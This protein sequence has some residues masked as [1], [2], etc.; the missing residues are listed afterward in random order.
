MIY[1]SICIVVHVLFPFF[2]FICFHQL[3]YFRISIRSVIDIIFPCIF[4]KSEIRDYIHH[5]NDWLLRWGWNFLSLF[6]ILP[7]FLSYLTILNGYSFNNRNTFV[8]KQIT[9]KIKRLV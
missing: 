1:Q 2:R 8:S 6:N 9:S 4:S 7:A 5:G 3:A